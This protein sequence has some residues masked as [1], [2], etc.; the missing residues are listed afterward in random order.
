[1]KK[2]LLALML[3]VSPL[4]AQNY[5]TVTASNIISPSGAKLNG[6]VCFTAENEKG[7]PIPFQ[8]GGGGLVVS[9][10][11]CTKIVNGVV[12]MQVANPA[13]TIPANI[14]YLIIISSSG[15]GY[16]CPSASISGATLNLDTY[17][18]P[19][20]IVGPGP[21]LGTVVEIDTT[22]PIV[23][24][25]ITY[26]GAIGL[27]TACVNQVWE[28]NG[29]SWGCATAGGS[30]TPGAPSGSLQG[31]NAGNLGA[32]PNTNNDFT[33]GLTA[34]GNV[35]NDWIWTPAMNWSQTVAS[36]ITAGAPNT[37]TLTP[38]PVGVD[39]T[40]GRGYEVLL[41]GGG[42]SESA[43]TTN[44]GTCLS[45]AS[46]GTITFIPVFSY[47]SS[48][49]TVGSASFGIQ[50]T[51]NQCQPANTMGD[52]FVAN[53]C[54]V[55]IPPNGPG[56]PVTPV[57]GVYNY[58]IYGTI[59]MHTTQA[60]L[61]AEGVTLNCLERGP[62]LHLNGTVNYSWGSTI[63]HESQGNVVKG[64]SL[65]ST[66]PNA[67]DPAY[68]GSAITST[69]VTASVAT[70]TT[71]APHGFRVGDWVTIMFTDDSSY[72]GDTL[73]TSVPTTTSFT[74]AARFTNITLQNTP[75]VVAL[76]YVGIRDDANSTLFDHVSYDSEW[77]GGFTVYHF[78]HFFDLWDDENLTISHFNN[79]IP[80]GS[81]PN[82][83]GSAIYSGGANVYPGGR[84]LAP[85]LSLRDSNI[86]PTRSNGVTLYNSN[87]CY[88]E[89]T[90][91]QST[92][93]WQVYS[94][95]TTGNFQ[96]CHLRN[97]YPEST[98]GQNPTS[99]MESPYPGLGISGLIAGQSTGTSSFSITAN[100]GVEGIFPTG[101]SGATP[102]TYY[103]VAKC[104]G[105]GVNHS[106]PTGGG[107]STSPMQVL[108]WLSTGSDTI[109]V[110]W[111]RV[112]NLADAITYDV[113]RM[114]TPGSGNPYPS[115]GN[116]PGGAGGICGSVATGVT[117]ATACSGG[118]VCSFT[119]TGSSTT[120][121]YT[122]AL[123]N[124]AGTLAFWPGSIVSANKTITVDNEFGNLVGVGLAGNPIQ[125]VNGPCFG[126]TSPGGYST[127]LSTVTNVNNS[128]PNQA[129]T[130]LSDGA[131]IS[132]PMAFS[133]GRLNFTTTPSAFISPHHIITLIDSNPSLTQ[134]TNGNRP[135]ASD[136]DTY[137]G[138]DMPT[139]NT[140][141]NGQLSLGA[142]LYI[143]NYIANKGDNIS[144]L[145]RLSSTQ[146]RVTTQTMLVDN[147]LLAPSGCSGCAP[148]ALVGSQASDNFNRANG[149]LGAN[150]T[151]TAG[152]FAISSNTA[153]VTAVTG[154]AALTAYTG[155]TFAS[156]QY[157]QATYL[158]GGSWGGAIGVRL[159]NSAAT[160]YI[161]YGIAG[162]SSAIAKVVAGTVTNIATGGP[163]FSTSDI[164][165]LEV[166]GTS[167]TASQNG[168]VILTATDSSIAS[169]YPGLGAIDF[170]GGVMDNFKGG[171]LTWVGKINNIQYIPNPFSSLTTCASTIEGQVSAV[172]DSSTATWGATI[173]GSGSNHV[174]GYC[175]G[176]NWTVMGK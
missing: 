10:P 94:A 97:V 22:S 142:P 66:I 151:T 24:G 64:L 164:L 73:V 17:V 152:T 172:S 32:I 109:A 176:T 146:F 103:I 138:T 122:I 102:Y 58:N 156:N 79:P 77:D 104:V 16:S 39:A 53:Q 130:L 42:H 167:I 46:S 28:W 75:G 29:T 20:I 128:T 59:Y 169:G 105:S 3:L 13:N 132:A 129:A 47:S 116:C 113:I 106:C 69:T 33:T 26:H 87:G 60:T 137:I 125:S 158:A 171:D 11:Y 72:W 38:C 68:I 41:S 154:A 62:C 144:F 31:N 92:A 43:L 56:I 143:S 145:T 153:L 54:V 112:A 67:S 82:W 162:S 159:S 141:S 93:L 21:A 45:G 136:N 4:F 9:S 83:S 88:I 135:L 91:I 124:Y 35:N 174:L 25:P 14:F 80:L 52:S 2:L 74:F 70:V 110:K 161:L 8:V 71:A 98:L 55:K 34:W 36:N 30:G 168:A 139:T 101:G 5:T 78:N 19:S 170:T 133:K 131:E 50:E 140:F 63:S 120:S 40:S 117:Q 81:S 160:G 7:N 99:P 118:L 149:A 165:R 90:V 108:N 163:G 76:D 85:V 111:P 115:N 150:W 126:F 100:G 166:T 18:C 121:A 119:D 27:S 155:T 134:A 15:G 86:S 96:G 95:N 65:R 37:L 61:E 1:M 127:C 89:N 148:F 49:S 173:T 51:I 107:S 23:G 123:A 12:N 57:Q 114:T 84:Q 175:D 157:A 147:V 6:N 48:S 44:G